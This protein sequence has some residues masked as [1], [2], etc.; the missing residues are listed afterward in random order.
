MLLDTNAISA[1]A[2]QEAGFLKALRN[3]WAWYLAIAIAEGLAKHMT[4]IRVKM[5]Q[6]KLAENGQPG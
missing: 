1:W 3:D 4:H 6:A 2:E 5:G